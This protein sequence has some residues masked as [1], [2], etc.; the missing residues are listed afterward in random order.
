M[1]KIKQNPF[2]IA[3]TV[4]TNA[5]KKVQIFARLL[6]EAVSLPHLPVPLLELESI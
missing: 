5:F 2:F 1:I 6:K 3:Y 4:T